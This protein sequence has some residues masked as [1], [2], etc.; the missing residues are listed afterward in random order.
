ME[1][2]SVYLIKEKKV[3]VP[4]NEISHHIS[5]FLTNEQMTRCDMGI[6]KIKQ[7]KEQT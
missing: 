6:I 1:A 5:N 2:N 3:D 4:L 7:N